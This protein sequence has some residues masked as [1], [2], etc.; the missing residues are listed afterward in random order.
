MSWK[1]VGRQMTHPPVRWRPT[2]SREP[3]PNNPHPLTRRR[4]QVRRPL[5]QRKNKKP[6]R[7]PFLKSCIF[8][9]T[10]SSAI[11]ATASWMRTLNCERR[12]SP[13]LKEDAPPEG[14][15]RY[16]GPEKIVNLL[17]YVSQKEEI[18]LVNPPQSSRSTFSRGNLFSFLPSKKACWA[19]Q[20]QYLGVDQQY[21]R[22]FRDSRIFVLFIVR[23]LLV[24]LL[25]SSR[26]T[27]SRGSFLSFVAFKEGMLGTPIS[28]LGGW[29]TVTHEPGLSTA[30][31]N[32]EAIFRRVSVRFSRL[33]PAQHDLPH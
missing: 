10:S 23:I 33:Y 20:F 5:R 12:P 19:H 31:E 26:S 4:E 3:T 32:R 15:E 11:T 24:N 27:F 13:P 7:T 29:P 1:G 21:R 28:V 30:Y 16:R 18:L 22:I 17:N 25:Q 8:A 2:R 9:R 6:V 14:W